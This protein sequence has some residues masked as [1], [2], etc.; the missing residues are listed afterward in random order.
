MT[1]CDRK[2]GPD[3]MISKTIRSFITD[4]QNLTKL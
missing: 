1:N 2:E 4:F 3:F